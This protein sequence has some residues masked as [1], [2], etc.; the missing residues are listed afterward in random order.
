MIQS[1]D[2]RGPITKTQSKNITKWDV[3]IT[4]YTGDHAM[5]T[6]SYQTNIKWL[7]VNYSVEHQVN[8][9]VC[10]SATTSITAINTTEA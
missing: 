4:M 8:K 6:V 3:I 10:S 1:A 5:S 7:T 2:S 9:A